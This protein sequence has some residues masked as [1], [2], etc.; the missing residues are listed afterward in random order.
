M[1]LLCNTKRTKCD[2]GEVVRRTARQSKAK[3]SAALRQGRPIGSGLAIE[4]SRRLSTDERRQPKQQ[5]NSKYKRTNGRTK[6][7]HALD[8]GEGLPLAAM[9][10]ICSTQWSIGA[11]LF[12]APKLGRP[13]TV[14]VY[15]SPA[16]AATVLT[17]EGALATLA[18]RAV[19]P[20]GRLSPPPQR[21]LHCG[22]ATW[23]TETEE[24]QNRICSCASQP[25]RLAS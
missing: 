8:G 14:A 23:A 15:L 22:G 19:E 18:R 4:S 17:A 11:A 9:I 24:Q 12:S 1:L 13:H 5:N 2:G 10:R 7:D 6:E 20:Q 21:S 3:Q 25:A 16:W